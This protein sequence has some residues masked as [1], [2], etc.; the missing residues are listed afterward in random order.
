MKINHCVSLT[1]LEK[2]FAPSKDTLLQQLH[3]ELEDLR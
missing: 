2:V 3:M 1:Y